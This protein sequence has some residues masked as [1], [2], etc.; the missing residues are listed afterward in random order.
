MTSDLQT[1]IGKLNPTCRKGLEAAA[2]ICVSQTHY[3]VELEHY[4]LALAADQPDTDMQAV[5]RHY[6]VRVAD[7]KD[8]LSRFIENFRRGNNR[9]PALSP[10]ILRLLE[11][12]WLLS[13]L[14]FNSGSIRSGALLL[15][16]LE[17]DNLRILIYESCPAL[18]RISADELKPHIQEIISVSR[19]ESP[20]ERGRG[21]SPENKAS[22]IQT[23]NSETPNLELYTTDLTQ[24][25]K[26]GLIDPIYGRDAEI[27]QM[28][29]ILTRRRQ[30]NPILT[31]E[32]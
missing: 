10:Y 5:L 7:V 26:K 25:A 29:D 6:D 16:L 19:E 4:L 1:L 15:A 20:L 3:N 24:R 18:K 12:A 2:E 22:R 11:Q 8:D 31:G 27:G 17:H 14:Y 28:I 21:V 32:A 23:P 9:T 30:N 13:S